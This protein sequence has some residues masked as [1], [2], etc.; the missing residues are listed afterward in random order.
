MCSE[1][2]L[3]GPIY[4]QVDESS[5]LYGLGCLSHFLEDVNNFLPVNCFEHFA[6]HYVKDSI[7]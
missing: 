6:L 7:V 2:A 5:L 4:L 3:L 1:H